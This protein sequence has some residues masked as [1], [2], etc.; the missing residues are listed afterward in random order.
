MPEKFNLLKFFTDVKSLKKTIA[1]GF[2]LMAKYPAGLNQMQ[3]IAIDIG[4]SSINAGFFCKD[5]LHVKK[6]DTHPLLSSLDYFGLFNDFI[7]KNSMD[8]AFDGAIISSVVP[9]HTNILKEACEKICKNKTLILSPDLDTGIEIRI[10]EPAKLGADRIAESVAACFL[11][12]APV[13]VVDFGTATTVNFVCKGN[14][15]KGGAILPGIRLMKDSLFSEIAQLPEIEIEKPLS[16]I[17][18]NTK[19]SIISGIIYGTAGAAEKIILEA[20]NSLR[21]KFK[22]VVTGGNAELVRPFMRRMDF[23]EPDLVLKGL[24]FIYKRNINART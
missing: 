15:F 2:V 6:M 23:F 19:E 20:E 8:K 5:K 13:A 3:F 17:G 22:V 12:S 16:P 21:V 1:S 4:N 7:E 9:E 10:M 24:G 11:F 18:R 14:I